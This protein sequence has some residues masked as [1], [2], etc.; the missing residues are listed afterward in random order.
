MNEAHRPFQ[1]VQE[2]AKLDLATEADWTPARE[3]EVGQRSLS[4]GWADVPHHEFIECSLLATGA[5]RRPRPMA[6]HNLMS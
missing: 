3:D 1:S 6:E 2:A 5:S 4:P